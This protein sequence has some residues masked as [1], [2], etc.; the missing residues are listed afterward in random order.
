[1]NDNRVQKIVEMHGLLL[2]RG[3]CEGLAVV[4]ILDILYHLSNIDLNPQHSTSFADSQSDAV[5]GRGEILPC[6]VNSGSFVPPNNRFLNGRNLERSIRY[7]LV[8]F[9]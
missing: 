9:L 8:G 3:D 7:G 4:M 5:F 6:P 2:V 1:M